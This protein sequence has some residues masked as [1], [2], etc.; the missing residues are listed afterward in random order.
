VLGLYAL[1]GL[2]CLPALPASIVTAALL[3]ARPRLRPW[4]VAAVAAAA[5]AGVLAAA[6]TP[7]FGGNLLTFHLSGW[8]LFSI[9]HPRID[10]ALW[11]MVFEA[12]I[13]V[14]LGVLLGA[15]QMAHGDRASRALPWHPR[16]LARTAV[17]AERTGQ[18][19]AR[20]LERAPAF[21]GG[22][23]PPGVVYDGDLTSGQVGAYAVVP[24]ELRARAITIAGAPGVGKTVLLRRL[25]ANDGARGRR[26]VFVDAKATEPRLPA[27]LVAAYRAG[28]GF[29]PRVKF[30]PAEP[31]SGW[32]GDATELANRLLAVQE[33]SEVWYHRVASRVIRLACGAE[34]GPP[35]SAEELLERLTAEGLERL[36]AGTQRAPLVK[37][38]IAEEGFG[39]AARRGAAVR[40]LLRRPCWQVRRRLEL[41]RRRPRGPVAAGAG[42][43]RGHRRRLP[44]AAGGPGALRH[45]PQGPRRPRHDRLPG[46]VLRRVQRRPRRDRPGRA[47]PRRRRRRRVRGAVL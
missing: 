31:L 16:T 33:W 2:L 28:A 15:L 7:V 25:V 43:P 19:A 46:R 22:V 6:R 5:L 18:R 14:P 23:P 40:R 1:L 29:T 36:Y 30:W 24:P 8:A 44:A 41:R 10:L 42:R 4:L 45:R 3:R 17:T 11:R 21:V 13:G 47:A 39:G 12:P 9:T 38:L 27:E 20:A 26:V 32:Q 37:Q 34:F 35:R